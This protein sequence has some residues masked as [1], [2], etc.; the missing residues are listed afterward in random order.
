MQHGV[1]VGLYGQG[2]AKTIAEFF[3]ELQNKE[4][5]LV[6]VDGKILRT[7][8]VLKIYVLQGDRILKEKLQRMRDGRTRPRKLESSLSEKLKGDEQFAMVAARLA[9][10]EMPPIVDLPVE[11][12]AP[13]EEQKESQSYPGLPTLYQYVRGAV[14][15]PSGRR[16]ETYERCSIEAPYDLVVYEKD[17]K[18]GY[19]QWEARPAA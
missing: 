2:E 17:G 11:A 7:T 5:K 4:A 12:L 19:Y 1:P 18:I 15:V 14:E 16:L 9:D 13:E 8:R 3:E 6:V 10:E